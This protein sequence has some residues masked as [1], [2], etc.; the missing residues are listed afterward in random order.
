MSFTAPATSR[1]INTN[2]HEAYIVR[3]NRANVFTEG[4]PTADIPHV[5]VDRMMR[6]WLPT[7]IARMDKL[8]E[9]H[10][11]KKR[12]SRGFAAIYYRCLRKSYAYGQ[13]GRARD[14]R[15]YENDV[16]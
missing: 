10:C 3:C 7:L 6:Y 11:D 15:D 16:F 8:S 9:Q 1:Q 2:L 14:L 5:I 13:P 4:D 12:L